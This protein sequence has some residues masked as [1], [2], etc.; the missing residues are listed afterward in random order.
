MLTRIIS[1]YPVK[2]SLIT[3]YPHKIGVSARYLKGSRWHSI[4]IDFSSLE[5]AALAL[6]AADWSS[7]KTCSRWMK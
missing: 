4:K 6:S 3:T 5:A 7:V 2:V 1:L